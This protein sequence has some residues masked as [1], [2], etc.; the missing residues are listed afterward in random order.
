MFVPFVTKIRIDLGTSQML[1]MYK[2]REI[3]NDYE[4]KR[5]IKEIE[6]PFIA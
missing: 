1:A 6:I 2:I 3:K 5:K 4:K